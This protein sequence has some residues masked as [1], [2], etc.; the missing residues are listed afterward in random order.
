MATIRAHRPEIFSDHA[1][2]SPISISPPGNFFSGLYGEE[3]GEW[4]GCEDRVE[5][6]GERERLEGCQ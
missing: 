2:D 3:L 5:D 4:G 6:N 1:K